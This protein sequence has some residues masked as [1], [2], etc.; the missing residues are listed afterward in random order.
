MEGFNWL[1]VPPPSG[2]TSP[3]PPVSFGSNP[4]LQQPLPRVQSLSTALEDHLPYTRKSNEYDD[5]M[6]DQSI[7]LSLKAQDLTLQESKTYMRW[8]SDILARTN[9]RT[10]SM[11]DVY[12][13]LGNFKISAEIKNHINRIFNKILYSINIGEFFALLRVI[14]HTLNGAE[15]SRKLITL[16]ASVPTP[17]S[18]L[19]KK[20]QND[21]EEDTGVSAPSSQDQDKPLDLDSFTQFIL[22]GE[23]P[24]ARKAP[25][26]K[27]KSV[28][29]SDQI[30]TDVHDSA[31]MTPGHSPLPQPLDYSLPMN[32]LLNNLSSKKT[33]DEEAQILRDMEPQINHFQNLNSVDTASI[34]GVPS[35]IH[36]HRHS[37]NL[38]RPNMTGPAQMAH[39]LSPSPSRQTP[40]LLQ[41][42]M[43]GPAQM[44]RLYGLNGNQEEQPAHPQ[45]TNPEQ[46]AQLFSPDPTE[47]VDPTP[48]VSLQSFTDQMTGNTI[49]NTLRNAQLGSSAER[50][51][52]PP[53]VPARRN[54][55]LS[56]PIPNW[57]TGEDQI[58]PLK[59]KSQNGR[60]LPP[61]P[62]PSRRRASPSVSSP[63]PPALPPKVSINGDQPDPV[64]FY[65]HE[66]E[67]NSTSDILHDLRALQEEVDKIRD[68]TGG[69]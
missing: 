50:A 43:T 55:S 22:T 28:K 26:K 59:N 47:K 33:D 23:R 51:L 48:R 49:D 12:N 39:M 31:Q 24:D 41:P 5:S 1:N 58:S 6:G 19:S 21:E 61:P 57:N 8:Y 11:N 52:P 54:R 17:P 42:N 53:P 20:R 45:V 30:V 15:P 14:A 29:F 36:P 7:P 69:F 66:T 27:R 18:I 25:S 9:T 3:A 60:Q 44:A 40:Q 38:L 32:Q 37:E 13:F 46:M 56:S 35:T 16:P 62:P 10:I 63:Q 4:L 2:S 67:S 65:K 64:L 34:D 68:M